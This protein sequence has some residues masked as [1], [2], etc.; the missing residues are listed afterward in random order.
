MMPF[1]L[2]RLQRRVAP[3]RQPSADGRA[4]GFE[5][6]PTYKNVQNKFSVRYFLNLVLVDEEDR[7]YFKQQETR[8]GA[9]PIKGSALPVRWTRG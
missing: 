2:R 9:Q 8:T 6:T 7:R 4:A 1:D 5:L 3:K